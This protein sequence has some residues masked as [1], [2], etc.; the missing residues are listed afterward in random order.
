[1]K[2]I[3]KISAAACC[4][5]LG[6]CIKDATPTDIAIEDQVTLETMVGGIPAALVKAGS[7]GYAKDGQAWD[8][9][10][11]AIHLATESMTGDIAIT[12]N[13]GYD[14]FQQWGTNDALGSDYAVCAL[15]WN[16]YYTWIMMANN[17]ISLIDETNVATLGATERSYLGFAYTYRA[18]FYLD[19]VRLYEF[20]ENT[21]TRADELLGL[22]VPI[23]LPETTEAQAKNNPRATVDNVYDTV[24]FPDLEKA[25]KLLEN[26]TA[27]DKYTIS[28]ALVYGLKARAYLERGTA[29]NDA[30]AYQSAAEYARK[31]ITASGRTPLTQEEWED[32]TNGFN[33]A[34]SNN[35]WIWGLALPS[36]SVANLFCF[37]AHM[38][39]ENDWS[40]YNA[41]R[42]INRNLY[43]SIDI[44][45]FR[46]HS[47][48]DPDR[49]SYAYKSCRPDSKEYFAEKLADYVNIKFRPAQGAYKESKVGGAADHCCM[50]VEEM[51]FIEAEATAQAG[52]I[53]GGIRLLNEFMNSYRMMNGAVYDC[54]AK[55]T[56][57][58]FVN[59]LM[60]QKRIE[61]WGEGIVMFDMKR[62]DMSSKRGYVGT[63]APA[64]YRLNVDGRAPYW[65]LVIGRNE[66]Q[67]N[68][69]IA[70]QNNPDPSGLVEPWKG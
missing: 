65:N 67:N 66:A 70:N 54:S 49:R 58:S 2:N 8:F 48:L 40:A 46:R 64:S 51:Y 36:E 30:R 34:E 41:G 50:R 53:P 39:C 7:A 22:G 25:E 9:A 21:I 27:S 28:L 31:A 32:P 62:L 23:V 20:K 61:F 11:P 12:G 15:T 19:L 38:S 69:A 33:N 37:T 1:M 4:V 35:A 3:L 44:R 18:M 55:S 43:N 6:S 16:N 17:V 59:E 56:L 42:A 60:L 63:N 57:K 47:W 26:Y 5:L 24:I 10:L 52:D 14:W 68:T 13:I 45:D 29:K